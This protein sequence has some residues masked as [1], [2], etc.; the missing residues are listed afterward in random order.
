MEHEIKK[1]ITSMGSLWLP[2]VI[3]GL[4]AIA[5]STPLST[6]QQ[7]AVVSAVP[8]TQADVPGWRAIRFRMDRP[9]DQTRWEKDLMIAHQIVAPVLSTF[10]EKIECWRFHRRSNDDGAGH[11]FSFIF[12]G[13]PAVAKQ[14]HKEVQDNPLLGALI[15]SGEVKKVVSNALDV[16]TRTEFGATSDPKW[17]P[18]L[19]KAWP[20]FIMGVSRMWLAMIEEIDGQVE[21]PSSSTEDAVHITTLIQH[22]QAVNDR[23]TDIWQQEGYHALLHH[24]NAIYGYKPLI[25]WEKRWK[26]F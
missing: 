4:L 14:I 23:V 2:V 5:C 10:E 15:D 3:I 21:P 6:T 25:F 9:D 17:S 20:Y 11:Q 12:Y 1:T 13:S 26:A 8:T 24:L 16:A 18:E 19:Q 22:Y 7:A